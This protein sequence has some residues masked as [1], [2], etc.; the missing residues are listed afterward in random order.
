M[1]PVGA[2]LQRRERRA[3]V[4][5]GARQRGEVED[6]VDLLVEVDRLDHV[7]VDE[8]EVVSRRWAMFSSDPVS[9]LSTQIDAVA[10]LEQVV[11]EV[12]AEEAGAAGDD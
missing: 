12:R 3:Q 5:D 2:D 4:V 7:V 11:A 9:R 10:L 1:R 8:R 6:E